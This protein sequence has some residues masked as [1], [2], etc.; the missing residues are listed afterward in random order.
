MSQ[1]S[2]T[3]PQG[4]E[5]TNPYR[6][7]LAL[8]PSEAATAIGVGRTFLYELINDG[9]LKTVKIGSRRLITLDAIRALLAAR[10]AATEENS[11]ASPT[12][13]KRRKNSTKHGVSR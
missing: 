3:A 5:T 9:S 2:N 12:P 7:R 10:E 1:I 6:D 11:E 8:S 4:L 13:A